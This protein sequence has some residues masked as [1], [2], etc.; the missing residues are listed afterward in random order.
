LPQ[1]QQPALVF[2]ALQ[3]WAPRP[4]ASLSQPATE[5]NLDQCQIVKFTTMTPTAKPQ[6]AALLSALRAARANEKRWREMQA[7]CSTD[8]EAME[9]WSATAKLRRLEVERLE[10]ALAE[11]EGA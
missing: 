1:L 9:Q 6:N 8:S 4:L 5:I 11:A 10:A 2:W 7:E 3:A